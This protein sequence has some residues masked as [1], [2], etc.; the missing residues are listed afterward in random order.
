MTA[1]AHWLLRHRRSVAA[2]V[3][4]LLVT[5]AFALRHLRFDFSV[6]ALLTTSPEREAELDALD[7]D[8]PQSPI[9]LACVL[10]FPREL[11]REDLVTLAELTRNVGAL[12]DVAEVVSL[13]STH[14]VPPRGR[15]GLPVPFAR[16]LNEGQTV[17]AAVE[18]H[19]LLHRRLLS[20]DGRATPLLVTMNDRTPET[21]GRR[22]AAVHEWLVENAPVGVEVRSTGGALVMDFISATLARDMRWTLVLESVACTAVLALLFGTLHGTLLPL[23][24]VLAALVLSLGLL[25]AL[26]Q[27]ISVVDVTIPG[28]ITVIGVCDAVHM[29]HAYER[30]LLANDDRL[31]AVV[32]MLQ[33]VGLACLFTS[34]TT[35]LGFLSLLVSSHPA[36]RELGWKAAAAVLVTFGAVVVLLPLL[37]SVWRVR[38]RARGLL[39]PAGEGPRAAARPWRMVRAGPVLVATAVVVAFSAA[40]A[41]RVAV[42]SY[43]LEELPPD[44]P[45][46][47]DLRDFEQ[48]FHGWLRLQLQVH[49]DLDEPGVLRGLEGMQAAMATEPGVAGFDSYTLWV[50]EALG[51]PERADDGQLR[52]GIGLLRLAGRAFPRHL[53]DRDFRQGRL[54][55]Y[56]E[57][58]GSL[59]VAE[60]QARAE[61]LAAALPDDVQVDVRGRLT[62]AVASVDLVVG[63]MLES[64]LL[65]LLAITLVIFAVFRSWRLGIA[66]LL[67]NVLPILFALGLN[68]WL[69]IPLRIGIVMIYAVG[70][71]LA[72]DDSIHLMA[73]YAQERAAR[74]G[75]SARDHVEAA[76]RATGPA[77]VLSSAILSVGCL[78]Y[79]GADFRSM[80]DVGILLN[81][82]VLSALLANLLLLPHLLVWL[83]R[84][85]GQRATEI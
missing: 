4:V 77:L 16:S 48:R 41:S 3:A 73:R 36:I 75:A 79:L 49:G 64:F 57:D 74:P 37:L 15:P 34:V 60:L 28:L 8:L 29:L 46:C 83:G 20:A 56:L 69:G 59:R 32:A 44:A 67:P 51:N 42:D 24:V 80:R 26:G 66:S 39:A 9:D 6:D 55:F 10:T 30:E 21:M 85:R 5:A 78:C 53:V 43:W 13:T 1:F 2:A 25:A 45:V 58:V 81:A 72:V 22:T 71:G 35:A 65:S 84:R 61:Q 11:T 12:P 23:A 40:G 82:I 50:R 33:R 14:V 54:V 76:L 47:R 63:T 18:L 52:A 17:Q 70:L 38:P 7:A 19:P 68:G 62:E 31:R 27:P